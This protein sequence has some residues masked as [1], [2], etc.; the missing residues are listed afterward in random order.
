MDIID[1]IRA[2][3]LA[4]AD[5]D[6][7][8]SSARFFKEPVLMYGMKS[9]LVKQ[10]A[11]KY[12]GQIKS[13]QLPK[14]DVLDICA[15]LWESGMLEESFVACVFTES[16]DK[17]LDAGDFQVLENWVYSYV[18]NWASCDTLCNHT[19]GNLLA[20]YPELA[21]RLLIWAQSDSRWVKRASAVS[22]IIPVRR[23]LFQALAFQI[24]DTLLLDT[25]DMVQKGY[26]WLLKSISEYDQLAVFA[27]IMKH[28]D[29]MPRTS[30]RYAIEKLPADLKQ[31]AMV[32]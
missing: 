29:R 11:K 14:A 17:S 4:N 12:L 25:D 6:A 30:L 18:G 2:E 21:E 10:I 19:I 5:S 8:A 24:A 15:A 28:K 32:R 27:Y 13:A 3:L 22:F 7:K 16:M 1:E 9:K 31:Q 26:G 23:G 20:R